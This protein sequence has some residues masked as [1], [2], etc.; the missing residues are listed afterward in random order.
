[1]KKYLAVALIVLL[2]AGG[3]IAAQLTPYSV[4]SA[5]KTA[6]ALIYTVPSGRSV[7]FD[8]IV[9]QTDGTNDITFDI[10]D[11]TSAAGTKIIPTSLKVKG[12]SETFA[13]SYDPPV[14]CG[15][16]IYVNLTTSGTV[17]YVVLYRVGE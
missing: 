5:V 9:V 12:T 4:V 10:H 8:G 11:N 13:L 15:T 2:A 6:D 3:V 7:L 1:M 14:K 17:A 16:G